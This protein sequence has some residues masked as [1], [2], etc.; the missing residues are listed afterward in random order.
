MSF[1]N[2]R[3]VAACTSC[4]VVL[5]LRTRAS[6]TSNMVGLKLCNFYLVV[7]SVFNI[8][9][10]SSAPNSYPECRPLQNLERPEVV[11]TGPRSIA[12][13]YLA[14]CQIHWTLWT[15]GTSNLNFNTPNPKEPRPRTLF[16]S[17][18][19]PSKPLIPNP[20]L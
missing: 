9:L 17:Y 11:R 14:M 15:D 16:Y 5:I 10:I 12:A 20:Q 13:I 7:L 8:H 3:R 1:Q 2:K 6:V 4:A 19:D 18:L